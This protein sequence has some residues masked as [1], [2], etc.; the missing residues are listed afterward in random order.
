[1]LQLEEKMRKW[2]L[3]SEINVFL[4]PVIFCSGEESL[5]AEAVLADHLTSA[6]LSWFDLSEE[7]KESSPFFL[8]FPELSPYEVY[9]GS[10]YR[11]QC[12]LSACCFLS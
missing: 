10:S 8:Q 2:F 11:K 3:K 5:G 7:S 4:P 12:L 6:L 1:M 9:A